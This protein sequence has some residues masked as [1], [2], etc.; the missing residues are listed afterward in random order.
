MVNVITTRAIAIPPP[1]CYVTLRK[2]PSRGY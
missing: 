1:L 2:A